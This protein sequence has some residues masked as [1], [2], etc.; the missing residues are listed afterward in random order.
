MVKQEK[1]ITD[2]NISS[3]PVSRTTYK[4]GQ[5]DQYSLGALVI[6]EK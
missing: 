5:K 3:P 6:H 4:W 1:C 2:Y